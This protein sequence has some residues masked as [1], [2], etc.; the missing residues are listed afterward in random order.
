MVKCRPFYLPREF[1]ATIITAAYIPPD[2]DAKS[3]MS[4]LH[5]AIS[6]QQTAHPNAAF[7]V[8]GDFNHLK[9]QDSTPKI[10]PTCLLQHQRR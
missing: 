2:A 4:E 7:I 6:K 3:A 1:T 5:A 10:S 9:P 8:A